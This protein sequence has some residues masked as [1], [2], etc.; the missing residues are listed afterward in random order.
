[1]IN[2]Y[3]LIII[4]I[5]SIASFTFTAMVPMPV[6]FRRNPWKYSA[7][8]NADLIGAKLFSS[9]ESSSSMIVSSFSN[10]PPTEAPIVVDS[11]SNLLAFPFLAP[12]NLMTSKFLE[13]QFPSCLV[14]LSSVPYS[15]SI[16]F[17]GPI[18][19]SVIERKAR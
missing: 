5:P 14:V 3:D 12:S 9:F 19:G 18:F 4:S 8:F 11:T 7:I 16:I 13:L 10:V 6:E 1:M 17:S 15:T 2:Q